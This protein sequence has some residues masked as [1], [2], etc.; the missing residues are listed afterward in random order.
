[1]AKMAEPV[2]MADRDDNQNPMNAEETLSHFDATVARSMFKMFDSE[3]HAVM[4]DVVKF[5]QHR[6]EKQIKYAVCRGSRDAVRIEFDYLTKCI[7]D[8]CIS[9]VAYDLTEGFCLSDGEDEHGEAFS[10]LDDVIDWNRAKLELVRVLASKGF[11]SGFVGLD[12]EEVLIVENC[13]ATG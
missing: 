2:E 7:M 4:Q 11:R 10:D 1:M 3:P 12:T 8:D 13:W 5:M 9:G 6:A